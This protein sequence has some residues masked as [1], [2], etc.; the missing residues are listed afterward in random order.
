MLIVVDGGAIFAR[1]ITKSVCLRAQAKRQGLFAAQAFRDK[2]GSFCQVKRF[3]PAYADFLNDQLG[4]AL[5]NILTE[6]GLVLTK[7]LA[8][9]RFA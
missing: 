2:Q 7:K 1:G 9:G 5:D 3:L 8:A 4:E 6:Q